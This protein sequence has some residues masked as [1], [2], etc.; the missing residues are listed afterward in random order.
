MLLSKRQGFAAFI[1]GAALAGCSA[2]GGW[3]PLPTLGGAA[4]HVSYSG[5][6]AV[7]IVHVPHRRHRRAHYVSPSTKSASLAIG[8]TIVDFGLT[9]SSPGCHTTLSETTCTIDLKLKPGSYTGSLVTYD[10]PLGAGKPTGKVLS[11]NQSFPM[12]VQ[13]G[14]ANSIGVT[15]DGVPALMS[16]ARTSGA[17][18]VIGT[19]YNA[20]IDLLGGSSSGSVKLTIYDPDENAIVGPGAPTLS[21]VSAGGGF[22]ATHSGNTIS[23]AAPAS[24]TSNQTSLALTISSPACTQTGA[25]CAPSF[26]IG[27]E[28]V[29]AIV[30]GGTN[31]VLLEAG[32]SKS[33]AP[34]YGTV[35]SGIYHPA[36]VK[37][38]KTGNLFVVNQ[39]PSGGSVLEYVAPYNAAPKTTITNGVTQPST[40]DL[41]P[42]GS[43]AV[44]YGGVSTVLVFASPYNG[45]PVSISIAANAIAFDENNNLWIAENGAIK[46][47]TASSSYATADVTITDHVNMPESIGIDNNGNLYVAD[48]GYRNVYLYQPPYSSLTK[49]VLAY[50]SGGSG[51]VAVI[52][53]NG[54]VFMCAAGNNEEIYTGTPD[55]A[56][57]NTLMGT[58]PTDCRGTFDNNAALWVSDATDDK[59]F[60]GV[61]LYGPAP[62]WMQ[63]TFSSPGAIAAFPNAFIGS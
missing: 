34:H 9:P 41:A 40:L 51:T 42:N 13:P 53:G 10:G 25:Q 17:I 1:V 36:D 62:G 48:N 52:P 5:T 26:T 11:A 29:L 8:T 19:T 28:P 54:D 22:H 31:T 44:A 38:D 61:Y 16:F 59:V 46:R 4:D 6:S 12:K 58:S 24:V 43:L 55:I 50:G 49:T 23:I 33:T 2:G 37:F 60:G 35:S 56:N 30:N 27:F 3:Q 45:T 7:L 63:A 18:D 47:F 20:N 32:N 15:L 21:A 39:S 14:I 57:L